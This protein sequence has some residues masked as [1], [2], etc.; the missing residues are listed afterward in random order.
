MDPMELQAKATIAAALI[1]THAVK[2]PPCR[3]LP[4][5]TQGRTTP[6]ASFANSRGTSIAHSLT[7]PNDSVQASNPCA[8]VNYARCRTH[9]RVPTGSVQALYSVLLRHEAFATT[10]TDDRRRT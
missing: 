9:G 6:P 5:E 2:S 1:T 8:L 4:N 3:T 7:A 10:A